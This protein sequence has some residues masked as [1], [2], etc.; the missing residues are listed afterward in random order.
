MASPTK[1]SELNLTSQVSSNDSIPI[2]R[3]SGANGRTLRITPQA[4]VGTQLQVSNSPTINILFDTSTTTL[5]ADLKPVRVEL[6]G[7][8]L[9]T[10]PLSS[11]LVGNGSG[12]TS[13]PLSSGLDIQNNTLVVNLD[14]VGGLEFT[15]PTKAIRLKTNNNVLLA[16]RPSSLTS[17]DSL[18]A[19]RQATTSDTA[20][21]PYFKTVNGA[22]AWAKT[23]LGVVN[24]L[25]IA[26]DEDSYE[27]DFTVSSPTL[28]GRYC[29]AADLSAGWTPGFY[30]WHNN[31]GS[32]GTG[33]VVS[34]WNNAVSNAQTISIVGRYFNGGGFTLPYFTKKFTDAPRKIICNV[35]VCTNS[36][37]TPG[38]FTGAAA[39]QSTWTN[40]NGFTWTP[41]S[42]WVP[43]RASILYAC[44]SPVVTLA[45][46]NVVT[47]TNTHDYYVFVPRTN[48]SVL[49]KNVT[50]TQ[51]GN[52]MCS[53]VVYA[54]NGAKLSFLGGTRRPTNSSNV[55]M[56]GYGLAINSERVGGN[57][58]NQLFL[59]A[60]E[61]SITLFD[62]E[63]VARPY[64]VMSQ[65]NTSVILDGVF[66]FSDVNSG[67]KGP[68]VVDSMG[69]FKMAGSFCRTSS[70]SWNVGTFNGA[71]G[72]YTVVTNSGIYPPDVSSLSRFEFAPI[73][74][75]AGDTTG[76]AYGWGFT[77]TRAAAIH[78][79][80]VLAVASP[81][82][83]S[84]T[85]PIQTSY[86]NHSLGVIQYPTESTGSIVGI[87]P[88]ARS[89]Y[90]STKSLANGTVY[91]A[92]NV[93]YVRSPAELPLFSAPGIYTLTPPSES[94]V[95]LVYK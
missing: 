63:S 93:A 71:T 56:P 58:Y 22:F 61:G 92:M 35:F 38:S 24:E 23:N 94:S 32:K 80:A 9:Q 41:S 55:D 48:N 66:N 26:L 64:G 47:E 17:T 28:S 50:A 86:I 18:T 85:N 20:L 68:I 33:A 19:Y 43:L 16:V 49:F 46:I 6:G 10:A 51:R 84:Y 57:Y 45:D 30:V 59:V 88:Q 8:G 62:A 11:I 73:G 52:G 12:Y 65:L 42:T 7:T 21:Q 13:T 77:S 36:S 4:L 44:L 53:V 2:A 89:I 60:S 15:G 5:S 72:S 27:T 83:T 39:T 29:S 67:S 75:W 54:S 78:W 40:Y 25:T 95:T 76:Q 81:S 34:F 31:S 82:N 74:Y 70:T 79:Q 69:L 37:V 90:S 14:P 1:I 3:G 87:L 91:S